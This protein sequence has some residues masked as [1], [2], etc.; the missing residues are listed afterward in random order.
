MDDKS[1][2]QRTISLRLYRME[3]RKTPRTC[4]FSSGRVLG[5]MRQFHILW[6]QR[7]TW[8]KRGDG[9][10]SLLPTGNPTVI[11][12]GKEYSQKTFSHITYL[13]GWDFK[14]QNMQLDLTYLFLHSK[15]QTDKAASTKSILLLLYSC[16]NLF[17]AFSEPAISIP[18]S[19]CLVTGELRQAS[20]PK[21][22]EPLRSD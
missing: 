15:F 16:R 3:Q 20:F 21:E 5:S 12:L 14:P 9:K 22:K 17:G 4:L 10:V 7:I 11:S 6:S 19:P 13:R 2:G 8:C 1:K 18:I